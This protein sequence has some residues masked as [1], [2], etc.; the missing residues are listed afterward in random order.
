LWSYIGQGQLGIKFGRQHPASMY[1]LDF[2][3]H[4]VKLAIE[5]DGAIQ[6]K[7]YVRLNDDKRQK[8]LE[9]LEYVF[10]DFLMNLF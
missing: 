5:L 8:Y 10:W 4:S 3:A 7:E 6:D 9:F 1:I 2:Y